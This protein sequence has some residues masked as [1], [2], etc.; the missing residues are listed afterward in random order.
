[1]EE[2]GVLWCA[3]ELHRLR[4]RQLLKGSVADFAGAEAEF[5]RAMD[6]ARGQSAKLW[7]LRA[8]V[9]LARLWRDQDRNSDAYH[10]LNPIYA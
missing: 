2:T 10:L 5:L 8:A 6:I 7:E 4:G 3:A 1:V 9:S